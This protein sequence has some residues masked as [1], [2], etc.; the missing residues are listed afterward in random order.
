[1]KTTMSRKLSTVL[2][3][4]LWATAAGCSSNSQPQQ[5]AAAQPARA[6]IIEKASIVKSANPPSEV[7]IVQ[8]IDASGAMRRADGSFSVIPPIKVAQLGKQGGEG[9]W[10][11]KAR[12]QLKVKGREALAETTSSFRVFLV[13][14]AP[15]RQV[16]KAELGT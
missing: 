9:G 16:W 2:A 7:E 10:P 14:E 11:V 1:M 8:A 13:Q 4:A 5:H 12:F 6:Q 3:L 15:G